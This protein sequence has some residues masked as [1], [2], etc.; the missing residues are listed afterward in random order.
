MC[1]YRTYAVSVQSSILRCLSYTLLLQRPSY[2]EY[3][4]MNLIKTFMANR[5]SLTSQVL[6]NSF[7]HVNS[8]FIVPITLLQCQTVAI[9]LSSHLFLFLYHSYVCSQLAISETQDY[10]G[11]T[12]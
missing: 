8:Y 7:S 9:D 2:G 10:P 6:K 4:I 3:L 1:H 12:E 5:R 11:C